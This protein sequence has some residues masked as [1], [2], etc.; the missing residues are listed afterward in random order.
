MRGR[1]E[2]DTRY[3]IND[4]FDARRIF[5]NWNFPDKTSA[6][7]QNGREKTRKRN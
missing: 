1:R 2:V 5:E 4:T 6:Y 3:R 7:G